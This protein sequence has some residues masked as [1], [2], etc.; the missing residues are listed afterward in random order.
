MVQ[1][2]AA[3]ADSDKKHREMAE[4]KNRADQ[5]VYATEKQLKDLGDK[6]SDTE[7]NDLNDKIAI[8]NGLKDG[9]DSDALENAV[10]DLQQASFAITE[11]LYQNV[12][13]EGGAGEAQDF[14][15]DQT[16]AYTAPADA[17]GEEVIDAEYKEEK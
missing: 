4:R 6:L 8:V 3:N 16:Q 15:A 9:E 2:A 1:E 5:V 12:A 11:K 17:E 13:P 14:N 10:N 7:K